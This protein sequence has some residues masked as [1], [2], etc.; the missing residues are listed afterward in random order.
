[1]LGN[2]V[3]TLPAGE[4]C[5]HLPCMWDDEEWRL[6]SGSVRCARL[7]EHFCDVDEEHAWLSRVAG[8]PF[9]EMA[10]TVNDYR[11]AKAM[12][13]CSPRH[14]TSQTPS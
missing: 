10:P 2:Y 9:V 4:H 6:L 1:M 14:A 7:R 11:Y 12:V 8:P 3:D 5:E 13:G